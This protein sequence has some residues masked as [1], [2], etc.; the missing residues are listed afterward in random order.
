MKSN[1]LYSLINW[2]KK[3]SIL[4]SALD[5]IPFNET[6]QKSISELRPVKNP[7]KLSL[8][9]N[10]TFDKRKIIPK[11]RR[12]LSNQYQNDLNFLVVVDGNP[13]SKQLVLK[14]KRIYDNINKKGVC[15]GLELRKE[16]AFQNLE[17]FGKLEEKTVYENFRDFIADLYPNA[18]PGQVIR[19][20]A[21]INS[22]IYIV[23]TPLPEKIKI[24]PI[25]VETRKI[26]KVF[27]KF[28]INGNGVIDIN[29]LKLG[30]E[31]HFTDETIQE[32]YVSYSR[33]DSGLHL[34]E[35]T[36]MFLP[37]K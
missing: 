9:I 32:L 35:F 34:N 4:L 33:N 18:D 15:N 26:E 36:E 22:K 14:L 30:L 27:R 12:V 25:D 17:V 7:K 28:D 5:N 23:M 24:T 1:I 29:E 37:L 20:L 19:I 21:L 13:V 8:K 10:Q 11:H 6:V 3:N 31:P 16:I 2:V